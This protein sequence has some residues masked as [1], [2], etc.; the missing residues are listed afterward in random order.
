MAI[1]LLEFL[2]D[3]HAGEPLGAFANT[4]LA[5]VEEDRKVLR[6]IVDRTGSGMPVL[7]ETAAWIGEK[8][9]E[10]KFRRGVFGAFEALEVL[11][12]GLLGKRALW[13][14]LETVAETDARLRGIDFGH[15]AERAEQQHSKVE[16]LR[17]QTARAALMPAPE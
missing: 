8:F 14:A 1:E 5:D 13:R 2:R 6:G 12:L 7:K 15:L 16:P 4:L 3:R 11:A 10:L 17:L 9:N